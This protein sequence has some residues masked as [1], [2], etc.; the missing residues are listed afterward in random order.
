MKTLATSKMYV[1][2]VR[3]SKPLAIKTLKKMATGRLDMA[4]LCQ[5]YIE[6]GKS[7]SFRGA[8]QSCFLADPAALTKKEKKVAKKV[9]QFARES[10]VASIIGRASRDH[11]LARSAEI[12]LN[13]YG[14]P[15]KVEADAN[16]G[17]DIKPVLVVNTR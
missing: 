9:Y 8:I 11:Q 16:N 12:L 5:L 6:G 4:A 10:F 3:N 1:S 17:E 15:T 7:P 2:Y 14:K 13:A